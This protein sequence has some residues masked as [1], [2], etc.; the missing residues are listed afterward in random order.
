MRNIFAGFILAAGLAAPAGAATLTAVSATVNDV[1]GAIRATFSSG[2][3]ITLRQ[4]VTVTGTGVGQVTFR[5]VIK[6]PAGAAV[7]THNGNAA[8]STPGGA[9][10]QLAGIPISAFYSVPGPYTYVPEAALDG[11][12]IYPAPVTFTISSPNITLVYPPN[13]AA[14][15]LSAGRPAAPRATA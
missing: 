12:T 6:S 14:R 4:A 5:F 15:S 13:G 10:S 3:S 1:S 2:E 11:T 7:F 9:Q 8:P